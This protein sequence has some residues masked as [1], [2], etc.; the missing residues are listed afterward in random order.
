MTTAIFREIYYQDP[1][2]YLENLQDQ[3]NLVFLDSCLFNSNYGRYSY[4]MFAPFATLSAQDGMAYYA[5]K[6]LQIDPFTILQQLYGQFSQQ[7]ITAIPPFQGGI[8]GYW[9]YDLARSL[10]SLP[11]IAAQDNSFADMALGFY[12]LVVSF[13]H[14]KKRAYAVSSGFPEHDEKKNDKRATARLHWLLTKISAAKNSKIITKP[15]L[16]A[17]SIKSDFSYKEYIASVNKIKQYI[18]A[19][20]VFEVNL[21]QRFSAKVKP[22]FEPFQL[23]KRLRYCNSA[24]F[25]A[26]IKIANCHILSSSPERFVKLQNHMLET[27]PIKGTIAAHHD[28]TLDLQA[29]QQLLKSKKDQAENNMIVDLMRNDFSKIAEPHSVTVPQLCGLETYATLHQLV[30]VVTAKLKQQYNAVD[31]LKACFPGGSI[32]GAP[33]IRAMEII[34]ELEFMRRG[35]YCG[36]AGYVGFNGTMDTSILIRSFFLQQQQL[37]W[38]AGGAIILDSDPDAEYQESMLK[39]QALRDALCKNLSQS[40]SC[41]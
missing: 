10:E 6:T 37:S 36:S 11:S 3:E 22:N 9:S 14:L 33:K 7:I 39:Q 5:G 23:Y 29:Q 4:I 21:A 32:T 41:T 40:T 30:S 2:Y 16:D 27:R 18:I 26:F 35:P 12:D 17:S 13:D 34:E 8:A 31:V 15:L 20:D 19:G 1:L 38:Y 25:S 24:P 28:V